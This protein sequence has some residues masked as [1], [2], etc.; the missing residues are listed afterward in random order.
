MSSSETAKQKSDGLLFSRSHIHFEIRRG[1]QQASAKLTD[2]A[3]REIR[4]AADA[5]SGCKKE[6]AGELAARFGVHVKT[7]EKVI[8]GASWRHVK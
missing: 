6:L 2:Q 7:I 5:E 1:E 8:R 3:V 4:R